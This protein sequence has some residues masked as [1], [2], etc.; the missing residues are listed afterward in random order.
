M[1]GVSCNWPRPGRR[2]LLEALPARRPPLRAQVN[3]ADG[4]QVERRVGGGQ[5][6]G[7]DDI[8]EPVAD[9]V[10]VRVHSRAWLPRRTTATRLVD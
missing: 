4:Q 10:A 1:T 3:A 7:G 9:V 5:L 8:G 6:G 2:Q